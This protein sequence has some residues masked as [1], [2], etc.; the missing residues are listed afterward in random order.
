[1]NTELHNRLR[2]RR[3]MLTVLTVWCIAFPPTQ[4][5]AGSLV[6]PAWSFARGNVKI[7]A[8]PGK[9]ADAEPVVVSGPKAPWGWSVEY[10]VDIPVDGDYTL[11]FRYATDE[12]R[13]V[14]V[15]FDS[16]N[17]SKC[18]KGVTFSA[19]PSAR[20]NAITA[21]SSGAKWESVVN[22]F[23]GLVKLSAK[24][25]THTIKLTRR[26]PLPH[27]VTLRLD[28]D[29]A[30]PEDYKPPHYKVRNIE[31]VPAEF[32]KAL[33]PLAGVDLAVLRAPV[34]FPPGDRPGNL[35]QIPAWTYDRGNVRI[36]ANPDKY[37]DAGPVVGSAEGQTGPGSIE[38]DIDFPADGEYTLHIKYAS[39]AARPLEVL[40]DDKSMGVICV[41]VTF[42]TAPYEEP[43]EFT[44]NSSAA[45]KVWEGLCR[46][47]K[48][49]TMKVSKGKHTLKLVREGLM[50]NLLALHLGGKTAAPP[51]GWKRSA[52]KM[53]NFDKVPTA[54]RSVF[55]PPGAVNIAAL[56]A[57]IKDMIKT[58]GPSY[59][60]GEKYLKKLDELAARPRTIFVK[61]GGN[62][63]LVRT[64][65]GEEVK[66]KAQSATEAQLKALRRQALLSHPALGF[67]KLLF[68]KRA[69]VVFNTYQDS[70]ANQVGGNLCLLSPVSPEGKVTQLVPELGEGIFSR[71]SLSFDAKKI[72]FGF[73][74]KGGNFRIHEIEIDPK[75]G[76]MKPGS[77]RQ[78][79]FA[80]QEEVQARKM[81]GG[82][83]Y[84]DMDPCHLPNGTIMFTSTR[85]QRRV[86]CNPSI[87]TTLFLMD[88]DGKGIRCLSGGPLSELEP[89]VLDDGRIVFTRWEY[90]DKGLGNGQSLWS[91]RPDGS[92]VD[93]V[94]KNSIIRPAQMLHTRS[95]PGSRRLITVGSPHC[96]GRVGGPVIL[97][98]NRITRRSTEAMT[99]IT[100]EIAYPCMHQATW[101]MGFFLEPYPFSEKFFLISH[102]PGPSGKHYG[103]YAL[104]AWGNRAELYADPKISCFQ[105]TPL[106]PR[107]KPTNIASIETVGAQQEKTGTLFIQDVYE[108]MTG[109]KRGRVKY[110]RVMGPLPWPWSENGIFRLGLAGNVHRKKVYGVAK[111]H[112]DGSAFFTAPAGENIFFQALDENFMVL[113]HMPTFI[114]MMPGEHR[115]CIGCHELRKK[116]PGMASLRPRAMDYPARKLAPQ[117]GDKG[118]RMV[119]YASDVQPVLDKHCV[120]C[121]S[122]KDAKARLILTGEPTDTWNRSYENIFGRGLISS[123]HCGFGRSGFRP[124]PPLTFGS[125][126]SKLAAQIRKAPCKAKITQAEFVRIVTWIDANGPYYGT[127]RGKRGLKHRGSPDFRLPPLVVKH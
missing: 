3:F 47:G 26:G 84:D 6:I 35:L 18:C 121:H 85:S 91:V 52:L 4:A 111:V 31:S 116:A 68:V 81:N 106:R 127:Y 100:P 89:Y 95:I 17:I 30:F 117:P 7:D 46:Q 102:K 53:P 122:G 63:S 71:F 104:D 49:A 29:K 113:Q 34:K 39:E 12:A 15:F 64:W 36:Y 44:S 96:G 88:G 45:A 25:G 107:R 54:H 43:V 65:A 70:K 86:F 41:N 82:S 60:D 72:A 21:K 119:H 28:T 101:N 24:K 11:H 33:K 2:F 32:R 56:R 57:S 8:D 118:P 22:R 69:P 42:G 62:G 61:S 93:H 9:Y 109:I 79:T 97:V 50:P 78:L 90:V 112:E 120:V 92:G 126:L 1:M 76:L 19:D 20:S 23:G 108:G 67:D 55:L 94:Y 110:V 10:D 48:P 75:T 83:G 114:N 125:H 103:L 80:S 13:P 51:K 115:S 59:P 16:R 98:D 74:K 58:L 123:R 40:I 124:E 5:E 14:Q 37:A 87:V 27:L 77:L 38:Y 99:C 73:K 66:G 105:P